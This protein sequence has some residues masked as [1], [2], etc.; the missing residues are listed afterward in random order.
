MTDDIT[1]RATVETI[2]G[3]YQRAEADIAQACALITGATAS[4]NETLGTM[5][6]TRDVEFGRCAHGY[7]VNYAE[8]S[9]HIHKMRRQ[10][11]ASLVERLE[12]RRM[13]SIE[14]AKTLD[15]WLSETTE[16]VTIESVMGL[17]R[18]YAEQLPDM[19]AE[20]VREVYEIL[21]PRNSRLVT[22]SEYELGPKVIVHGWVEGSFMGGLRPN[23][24][25]YEYYRALE[26]VF[27]AL[28]GRGT[29]T[30][31]WRGVLA[32]A[33]E[34]S[35]PATNYTGQTDYFK[36]RACKN[37]NL[38]LE[39]RRPDLVKRF[40]EIAGGKRL[41]HDTAARRQGPKAPYRPEEHEGAA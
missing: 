27:T 3:V 17:F 26:N 35:T 14:R 11:W 30:K 33:V 34:A 5:G 20:A 21:R 40:N 12:L 16:E 36:F 22:N 38:H 15:K 18:T 1:R 32:D 13:M 29:I 24:H 10:L 4:I 19:I 25:R 31:S 41:K 2:V 28:D 6:L 39:F 37:G 23:Y 8:P 7:R 9:E